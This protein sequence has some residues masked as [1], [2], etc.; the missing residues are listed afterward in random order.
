MLC[1]VATCGLDLSL[2]AAYNVRCRICRFHQKAELVLHDGGY[3]RW[4]HACAKL[5]PIECFEG[6]KTTCTIKLE[7]K[8]A[9][10][11]SGKAQRAALQV[12]RL[13]CCCCFCSVDRLAFAAGRGVCGPSLQTRRIYLTCPHALP[14]Q[15][16]CPSDLP[17]DLAAVFNENADTMA[18]GVHIATGRGP[19]TPTVDGVLEPTPLATVVQ[20]LRG[21]SAVH[22]L[23]LLQLQSGLQCGA[24][25]VAGHRPPPA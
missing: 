15:P 1:Q 5:E 13:C 12:G 18:R 14:L 10:Y 21:T 17:S 6:C 23:R 22:L 4:C 2:F 8:R 19:A 11:R 16:V 20:L 24:Q 3:V 9:S 25:A 7:A